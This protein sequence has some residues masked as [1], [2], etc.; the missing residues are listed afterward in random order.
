MKGLFLR[1]S[2]LSLI[3]VLPCFGQIEQK[4]LPDWKQQERRSRTYDV[5]HIK[6]TVDVNV[7]EKQLNGIAEIMLKPLNSN[8][9]MVVLDA[10]E[11]DIRSVSIVNDVTPALLKF[12]N[13]SPKLTIQL[14]KAYPY[15]QLIT[16]IVEYKV[17][18]PNRGLFF[19]Q[20]DKNY[21]D[22]PYQPGHKAKM[23]KTVIGSLAMTILT[24]NPHRNCSL[25]SKNLI[26]RSLT[27]N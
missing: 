1:S 24:I 26:R 25:Q 19:I 6:L 13:E 23:R 7:E 16:L 8:F 10:K 27:V 21:P 4:P 22:K 20:P 15:D 17:K 2:F 18:E 14:D 3:F 11:L 5:E 9:S 12:V